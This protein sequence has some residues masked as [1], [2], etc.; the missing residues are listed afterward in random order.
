MTI[1]TKMNIGS[2][3]F[4]IHEKRVIESVVRIIKTESDGG[5]SSVTYLCS[6]S[7]EA[8]NVHI[9]VDQKDGY[10]SKEDLIKS[11]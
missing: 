8:I 9:K 7:P 1:E 4:F 11:L 6:K 2:P 10:P 5:G 3:I